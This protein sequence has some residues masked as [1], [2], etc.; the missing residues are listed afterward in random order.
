MSTEVTVKLV[1]SMIGANQKQRGTLRA[2]GL[3]KIRQEKTHQE[4]DAI[5]GMIQSVIHMVEVRKG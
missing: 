2:L 1:R 3:R 4:N 5:L